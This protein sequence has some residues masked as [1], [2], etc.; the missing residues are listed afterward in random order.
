MLKLTALRPGYEE[1]VFS[2]TP[3][4][5][6]LCNV[7]ARS[8]DNFFYSLLFKCSNEKR[9]RIDSPGDWRSLLVINVNTPLFCRKF[10]PKKP[11]A[12]KILIACITTLILSSFLFVWITSTQAIRK[13]PQLYF[14]LPSLPKT[15][16]LC[17]LFFL[18]WLMD[19][20]FSFLKITKY[21]KM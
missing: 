2:F 11:R 14:P 4:H 19:F 18:V 10:E 13:R 6:T 8:P 21:K 12:L 15:D 16:S 3:Q 7:P 1:I 20:S 9:C 5:V 17:T